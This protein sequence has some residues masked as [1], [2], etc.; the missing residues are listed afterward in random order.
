MSILLF[1]AVV[2]FPS[3]EKIIKKYIFSTEQCQNSDRMLNS[4]VMNLLMF[5]CDQ[6]AFLTW[7]LLKMFREFLSEEWI[8]KFTSVEDFKLKTT[9]EWRKIDGE[10]INNLNKSMKDRIINLIC[11]KGEGLLSYKYQHF[12]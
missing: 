11:S 2:S 3:W 6:L 10:I 5:Y 12:W 8:Q 9:E 4:F 7:I 1:L